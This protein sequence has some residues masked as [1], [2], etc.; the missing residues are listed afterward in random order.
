[1]QRYASQILLVISFIL[2]MWEWYHSFSPTLGEKANS[3]K[4]WPSFYFIVCTS[5]ALL[6]LGR[7]SLGVTHWRIGPA[8]SGSVQ[9][10]SGL[11]PSQLPPSSPPSGRSPSK[12]PPSVYRFLF[13]MRQS[14]KGSTQRFVSPSVQLAQY[15]QVQPCNEFIRQRNWSGFLIFSSDE[16]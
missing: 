6:S 9:V 14:V 15:V 11:Q 2:Q 10:S 5:Q 8:G 12:A 7:Q 1:M 3:P 16:T 13:R 4:C